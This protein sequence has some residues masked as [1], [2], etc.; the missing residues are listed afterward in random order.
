MTVVV[1][2]HHL[3]N[4]GFLDCWEE[5]F[6]NVETEVIIVEDKPERILKKPDWANISVFSHK[7]INAEL[8]KD[9]WI[10]PKGTSAIRSY[11]LYKAFYR[12]PEAII[13]IDNDC[14]PEDEN[15]FVKGH[16]DVLNSKATLNWF[17]STPSGFLN[18]GTMPR[19]FPY[20]IRNNYEVV[21][22][23]GLWS[24]IPDYDAACMLLHPKYRTRKLNN[25]ESILIPRFNFYPMCGMNLSFRSYITPLMYFGLFGKEY[26][27]DQFDD[28]WCGVFSKK[29]I[30]HLELGVRSG[31]PSV[32]HKK[33][34]NPFINFQKQAGGIHWNEDVWKATQDVKLTKD[35]PKKLY[36]ELI[37]KIQFPD[38]DYFAKVKRATLIWL[39]Y[40]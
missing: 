30:D 15:Y 35:T 2:P 34:S 18:T 14:F 16:L 5:E 33:Q 13:T 40:F 36:K 6:N 22:N 20:T 39:D 31:Y 19:G 1:I 24:N 21:L 38:A 10:I 27:F 11:G 37:E 4:M 26:G 3:L 28:I 9:S 25:K 17:D 12:N 23:H 8:G 29:I 7:E 32:C